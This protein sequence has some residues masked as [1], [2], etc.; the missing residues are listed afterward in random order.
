MWLVATT[1]TRGVLR[2]PLLT[3]LGLYGKGK[4]KRGTQVTV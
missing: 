4:R 1:L 3:P 2:V